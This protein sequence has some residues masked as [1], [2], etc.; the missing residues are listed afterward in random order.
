MN[1]TFSMC[2]IVQQNII[3]DGVVNIYPKKIWSEILF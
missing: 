2:Q 1:I 3:W